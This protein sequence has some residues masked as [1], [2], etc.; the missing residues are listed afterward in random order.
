[1]DLSEK[2]CQDISKFFENYENETVEK[3]RIEQEFFISLLESIS[4]KINVLFA[5]IVSSKMEIVKHLLTFLERR[6]FRAVIKTALC[7][8]QK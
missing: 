6:S 7:F 4:I 8:I 5:E 1:M 2:I 3:E